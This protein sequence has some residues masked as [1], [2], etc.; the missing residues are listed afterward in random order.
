MRFPSEVWIARG[1]ARCSGDAGVATVL[2]IVLAIG[3]LSVGA[4]VGGLASIYVT[5]QRASVAADLAALGGVTSGCEAAERIAVAQGAVT[6]TC[7]IEGDDA[8]VT[9]ALPSPAILGRVAAWS[10]REAP[11]IVATA[12]AGRATS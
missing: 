12:R 7:F 8:V 10:G 9:V 6:V 3:L 2:G 5:H 4:V 1:R 11:V